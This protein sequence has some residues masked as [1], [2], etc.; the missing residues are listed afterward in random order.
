M[1]ALLRFLDRRTLWIGLGLA[2]LLVAASTLLFL[3]GVKQDAKALQ[4]RAQG[5]MDTLARE[6]HDSLV[7]AHTLVA[8][9]APALESASGASFESLTETVRSAALR[10]PQAYG[11]GV[12]FD[13]AWLRAHPG[14]V[15]GAAPNALGQFAIFLVR[16]NDSA[17]QPRAILYD[18]T[19]TTLETSLWYTR[20]ARRKKSGWAGPYFGQAAKT[21]FVAYSRPLFDS[22]HQFMGVA[23]ATMSLSRL[24]EQVAGKSG[25]SEGYV[26]LLSD[27][28]TILYHPRVEM[29]EGNQ[30]IRT[31]AAQTNNTALLQFSDSLDKASLKGELAY[32]SIY[33]REN[34][35]LKYQR[36]PDLGWTLLGVVPDR[37]GQPWCTY[38]KQ[39]FLF[40]LALLV[41]GLWLW[42]LISWRYIWLRS[43]G[44]A[45]LFIAGLVTLCTLAVQKYESGICAPLSVLV[46]DA[47]QQEHDCSRTPLTNSFAASAYMNRC[48]EVTHAMR[49]I[50]TGVELQ[51]IN[52][53]SA[54]SFSMT[55]YL[56][57]R[58][59]NRAD[60]ALLGVEFP[61]QECASLTLTYDDSLAPGQYVRGWRFAVNIRQPF[62]YR[63]Y[64]VDKEEFWLR[65]A[66]KGLSPDILLEPDFLGYRQGRSSLFGIDQNLVLPHWKLLNTNFSYAVN[67][68]S[69][70]YGKR[71]LTGNP[72][73][74]LYFSLHVRRNILDAFISHF[75]PL[76]VIVLMLFAILWVGRKQSSDSKIL[77]FSSL[78]G[79]SGCSG[80]FFIAIY[81]HISVRTALGVSEVVYMECFFFVTYAA[82]LF[83]SL[84][85]I[86][87]GMDDKSRFINHNDNQI[88]RLLYWPLITGI[89]FVCTFVA[90]W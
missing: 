51:T 32:H 27:N 81:N 62:N 24:R 38:H 1:T 7:P 20:A 79:A 56:W 48:F 71:T 36:I 52:F 8:S 23:F 47:R 68:S 80:L 75:I 4:A 89:L 14:F 9:L 17:P 69:S 11:S 41:L 83:V 39:L 35:R 42:C 67:Q 61:E 30:T 74:E 3:H 64:P 25:L 54:Y 15:A 53:T 21:H 45:L 6:I 33:T 37:S 28:G 60:T 26:T 13:P 29:M 76:L 10:T 78:S 22:R 55:G 5:S 66:P 63:R 16:R 46:G 18:Y 58:Y 77:G 72:T 87:V 73:P 84:N 40:V 90:F 2:T 31:V 19:D 12:A 44:V 86:L 59:R 34:T 49:S 50:P 65:M 88:S 57:Q 85:A 70:N 82:I 43:A